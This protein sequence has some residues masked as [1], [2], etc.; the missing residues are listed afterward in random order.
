MSA[1]ENPISYNPIKINTTTAHQSIISRHRL[2]SSGTTISFRITVVASIVLIQGNII[3]IKIYIHICRW[4]VRLLANWWKY[5]ITI[6]YYNFD[7][8]FSFQRSHV[9]KLSSL[10]IFTTAISAY[11]PCQY[12]P[13]G[14]DYKEITQVTLT[15]V[16]SSVSNI[17]TY[18]CIAIHSWYSFSVLSLLILC[19]CLYFL[20]E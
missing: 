16:C 13:R 7:T 10:W 5:T 15:F 9:G 19:V 12:P 2:I 3:D 1:R 18:S 8:R 6:R 4:L 11:L 20:N 17:L 14:T